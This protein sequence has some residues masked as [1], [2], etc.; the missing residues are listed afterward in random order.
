[1]TSVPAGVTLPS[2]LVSLQAGG[3][4]LEIEF[5]WVGAATA[6]PSLPPVVFLHEGLGSV[7][8]WKG[9]PRHLCEAV[10]RR[11]LVYSRPGYGRSTPKSPQEHWGL[12]YLHVQAEI[13]LPALLDA[14][15]VHLPVVLFGH[16][17]GGSI[18]LIHAA[19]FPARVAAAIVLAPHIFVEAISVEGIRA[20]CVAF[21]TTA[22]RAKLAQFHAD[23][24]SAFHGWSDAW[25]QPGFEQ[26]SIEALLPAIQCP[27]LAIQGLD[28]H[29][30]T[31]AQI[32][33][34]AARIPATR[35]LELAACGHVPHRDQ[36]QAV[37]QAT[38]TLLAP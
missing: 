35:L 20:T 12:D 25:L 22:L 26:W 37:I 23:V 8:M 3:R 38:R 19:R 14:L 17:D 29:Y 36:P 13:V 9:F 5:A 11:G 32:D 27:V 10:G 18:A 31:L 7:A 4:R 34:I 30:G 28:D 21:E 6:D 16:S 15:D 33:G 2:S 24:D 1:M